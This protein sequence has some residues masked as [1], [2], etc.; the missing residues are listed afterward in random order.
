M[1]LALLMQSDPLSCNQYVSLNASYSGCGSPVR[2]AQGLVPEPEMCAGCYSM[3]YT[4][5]GNGYANECWV[6]LRNKAES[7]DDY[8]MGKMSFFVV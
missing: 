2:T 4:G 7:L 6:L 8:S 3:L 1:W 5:H